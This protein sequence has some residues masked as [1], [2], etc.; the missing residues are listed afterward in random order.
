MHVS[1]HK[2]FISTYL[3]EDNFNLSQEYWPENTDLE[4]NKRKYVFPSN[5]AN[6]LIARMIKTEMIIACFLAFL[7]SGLGFAGTI[8][9]KYMLRFIN[10]PNTT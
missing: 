10:N 6:Q 7:D 1:T 5:N 3:E 9:I 8:L 4:Y 2:K